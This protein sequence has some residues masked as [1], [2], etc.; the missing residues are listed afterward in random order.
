MNRH[1]LGRT[2][3]IIVLLMSGS[4]TP[5]QAWAFSL[6][7]RPYAGSELVT[8]PSTVL[9]DPT[10]PEKVLSNPD[11]K[12]VSRALIFFGGDLAVTP[13]EMGPL[14]VSALLGFRTMSASTNGDVKDTLGFSYLPVG[15]SVDFALKKLRAS[16]YFS[17]D[18]GLG[19]KFSLAVAKPANE[20]DLKMQKLSRLRFGAFAEFFVLNSLSVF[21]MGDY[22]TGSFETTGGPL[23]IFDGNSNEEVPVNVVGGPN[24]M[25]ALTFGGGVAYYIPVPASQ[26]PVEPVKPPARTPGK[27]PAGKGPAKKAKPKTGSGAAP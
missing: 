7:I 11:K 23:T 4:A 18:L 20:L 15:L 27:K 21:G 25:S 3:L 6:G 2:R 19:A 8:I 17:Y 26:R 10:N 14:S 16:G 22:A 12:T 5:L 1:R 24:K 13:V 9:V